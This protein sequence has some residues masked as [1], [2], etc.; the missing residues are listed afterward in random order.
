MTDRM[1]SVGSDAERAERQR[2]LGA[3]DREREAAEQ[4]RQDAERRANRGFAQVYP[5]GWQRLRWLMR[6]WPMAAQ[7]YAFLGEH[8]DPSAGAVVC[9][10]EL[11][12]QELGCHVRTIRRITKWLDDDVGAVVRIRVGAGVY[13]YALDPEEVW[14]SWDGAKDYAAFRTKTLARKADNGQVRRRLRVMLDGQEEFPFDPETGEI[15]EG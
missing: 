8:L 2:D 11:L 13:A 4:A 1:Q 14:K 6:E 15:R 5:R 3:Q 7:L 12:A 10:Q 9:S